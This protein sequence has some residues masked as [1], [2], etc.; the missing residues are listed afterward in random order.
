MNDIEDALQ[1]HIAIHY[2]G[3]SLL[4]QNKSLQKTAMPILPV[5]HRE[6]SLK[7]LCNNVPAKKQT[8][9]NLYAF[10]RNR[11]CYLTGN[12][13]GLTHDFGRAIGSSSGLLLF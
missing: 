12:R 6:N 10:Y 1:Y 7:N 5:T 13:Y 8:L 4:L 9:V 11:F 3:A 2:K